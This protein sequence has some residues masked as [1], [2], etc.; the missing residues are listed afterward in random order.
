MSLY[1][2]KM[3]QGERFLVG[4][5]K[6]QLGEEVE[7]ALFARLI[8]LRGHKGRK[9]DSKKKSHCEKVGGEGK[10]RTDGEGEVRRA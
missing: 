10:L 7:L 3:A 6:R 2:L 1:L 5:R 9:R 8:S 4:L